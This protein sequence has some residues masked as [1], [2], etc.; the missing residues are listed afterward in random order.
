MRDVLLDH[1]GVMPPDQRL[2]WARVIADGRTVEAIAALGDAAVY[3]LTRTERYA[4]VARR[5]GISAGAINKAVS[6]HRARI[7]EGNEA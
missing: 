5:H 4:D 2:Q 3:E 6:R 1:L 7:Q